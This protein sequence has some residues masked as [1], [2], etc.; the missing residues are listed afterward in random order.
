MDLRPITMACFA[1]LSTA[2]AADAGAASFYA[3]A[4][5][6][7]ELDGRYGDLPG[8]LDVDV[9][10]KAFVGWRFADDWSVEAAW[11]EVGDASVVPIADFGFDT[12]T[13]GWSLGLRYVAPVDF[14]LAPYAKAGYFSFNESGETLGIAGPRRFDAD[15]S[16]LMLEVGA[17]WRLNDTFVLRAGY[18]WV[19]F[20]RDA[21]GSLNLGAE[22][23]F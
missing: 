1:L 20:E 7:Q 15:E 4:T 2:L 18:E 23:H 12:S 10:A 14:A 9:A 3:G 21:D 11:H 22:I 13:D 19:D 16:G 6:G 5:V 8:D 17:A